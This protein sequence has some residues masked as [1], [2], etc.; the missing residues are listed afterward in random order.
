MRTVVS[1]E[2]PPAP[3]VTDTKVGRYGSSSVMARHR[4]SSP[5]SSLGGKN[6]NENDFAPLSISARMLRLCPRVMGQA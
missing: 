5:A 4:R 2:V 1:R 3:Y 6:S